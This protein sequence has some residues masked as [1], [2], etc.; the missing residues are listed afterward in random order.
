MSKNLTIKW[1]GKAEQGVFTAAA[2]LARVL[3]S[4]G[5]YVQAFP[6][7]NIKKCGAPQKAFN[8]ISNSP[9][10]LHSLVLDA[11]I[12]AVL[13]PRALKYIDIKLGAKE[14]TIYV[15]NTT[16]SAEAV[17]EKFN[18]KK[19]RVFTFAANSTPAYIPLMAIIVHFMEL[20]PAADFKEK[21]LESLSIKRDSDTAAEHIKTLDRALSEVQE[22]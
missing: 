22:A 11:D 13:D 20:M 5:K 18:L 15:I 7:F 17:K 19:N 6:E 10:R 9:I 1:H 8:R 2:V 12:E 16:L 4:G 14:E 3:A 21:L